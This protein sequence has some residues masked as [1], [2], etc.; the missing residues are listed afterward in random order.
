MTIYR[1]DDTNAFGNE[2]LTIELD[3]EFN[4]I[5]TKAEFQ[6]G[7]VLKVYE[8]PVFPLNVSLT[9]EETK[10]LR[11][12]NNCYLRVYDENSLRETC[13]GTIIVE[14]KSE[15]VNES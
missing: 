2:F 1:N 7:T 13:E 3:N 9:R 14:T 8:N 12:Q 4:F 10:L 5:I 15:V 11:S 6:C